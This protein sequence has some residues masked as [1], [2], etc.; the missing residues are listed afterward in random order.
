[1]L[2]ANVRGVFHG[3]RTAV[4]TM[5]EQG[6]GHVVDVWGKGAKKPVPFQ[7]AYASSK[8]WNRSF[9]RTVRTELKG[10]GVRVHGYDP[11]W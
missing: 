4:L 9:T 2:D 7:N 3:T 11:A 5:L 6:S 1:M 8:A 10:T